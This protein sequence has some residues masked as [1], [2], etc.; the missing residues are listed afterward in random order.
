LLRFVGALDHAVPLCDSFMH[1]RAAPSTTE[2]F[3]SCD[4]SQRL[5][6]PFQMAV[7]DAGPRFDFL[8]EC[9][10]QRIISIANCAIGIDGS[11]YRSRHVVLLS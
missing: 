1:W 11:D 4:L 3:F 8:R 5:A 6:Q 10:F 9:M 2:K 7:S